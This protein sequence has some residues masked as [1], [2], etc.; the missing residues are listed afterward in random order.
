MSNKKKHQEEDSLQNLEQALTKSEAFIEKYYKQLLTFVTIIVIVVIA[1]IGFNNWFLEPREKQAADSMVMAELY[2][3]RDSFNIALNGDGMNEGFLDIID[4]YGMTKSSKLAKFYAG[5][6]YY[7]LND[8]E[9]AID[10][11]KK[12]SV[13]SIHL[14]P[15]REGLIGD[16]YI[17][18]GDVTEG[19]KYFEK[20]AKYNNELL[21]PIYLEKAAIAY[22]S[23]GDYNKALVA[24][25]TIKDKYFESQQ[26]AGAEKAIV[27]C[28][29]LMN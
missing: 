2:F 16:C 28:E 5:V 19:V 18:M 27:R 22:E 14:T 1:I 3:E 12:G 8:Y 26:A 29:Y 4:S 24:Y 21:A 6:C 9:T 10:Y 15:A 20:A 11:L 13:K 23:L 7:H 25:R 17:Q